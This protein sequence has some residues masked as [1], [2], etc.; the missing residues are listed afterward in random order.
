MSRNKNQ[1]AM[2]LIELIV[3][4]GILAIL[5]GIATV[6]VNPA[7]LLKQS[8]DVRRIADIKNLSVN[9]EKAK[10][11]SQH[12]TMGTP[13]VVYISLPDSSFNCDNLSLPELPP[14]FSYHCV[15]P[16]D[17]FNTGGNGWLPIDFDSNTSLT[18]V[19][20]LPIDPINSLDSGMYYS[21]SVSADNGYL[22][23]SENF[24]SEKYDI[25]GD[26]DQTST[27]GG[28]DDYE[29][30]KKSEDFD[31]NIDTNIVANTNINHVDNGYAPGWDTS[32][33]GMLQPSYGFSSGY[34]AS[35]ENPSNGYHAHVADGCGVGHS[36]CIEF[37]D[38]NGQFGY[39]HRA[40]EIYQ[41]WL[42]P[43][44]TYGWVPG[45][46][47]RVKFMAKTDTKGKDI[48]FGIMHWSQSEG[49]YTT[50]SAL[51]SVSLSGKEKWQKIV[52]EFTIDSD[53][54]VSSH[55]ASLYLYGNVG[56]EGTVWVDNVQVEYINP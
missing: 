47:V 38:L 32:L 10:Y 28:N 15:P 23:A 8:R 45:T 19:D 1:F 49:S 44:T 36:P 18:D 55:D 16:E 43:G 12:T 34:L 56:K 46:I 21:Y 33:N 4:A 48:Q 35:V 41:T 25:A 42:T 40:L 29:Y 54:D 39:I 51:A 24:E 20:M 17:L 13:G 7:E 52:E 14:G 3:A 26:K 27:D 50:N 11:N 9:I 5:A 31:N 6:S 30:E 37:V 2:A 53:W 22:I